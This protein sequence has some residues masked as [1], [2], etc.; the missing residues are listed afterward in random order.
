[1]AKGKREEGELEQSCRG[2]PRE[3]RIFIRYVHAKCDVRS[4]RVKGGGWHV[5]WQQGRGSSPRGPA[6]KSVSARPLRKS[7]VDMDFSHVS[8]ASYAGQLKLWRH[9]FMPT[10]YGPN[11]SFVWGNKAQIL[12]HLFLHLPWWRNSVYW[13]N[14]PRYVENRLLWVS[15]E[16]LEP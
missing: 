12:F 4:I 9:R 13:Q 8:Q 15:V 14:L 2:P 10:S 5:S 11:S 6:I 7:R 3:M 16:F 1:M